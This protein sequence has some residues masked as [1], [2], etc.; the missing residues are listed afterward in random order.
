MIWTLE[1]FGGIG[2]GQTD[3]SGWTGVNGESVGANLPETSFLNGCI[4]SFF[5]GGFN[6]ASETEL[7]RPVIDI[8]IMFDNPYK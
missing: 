8:R 4:S 7:T 2:D 1:Q 5:I 6:F 3:N